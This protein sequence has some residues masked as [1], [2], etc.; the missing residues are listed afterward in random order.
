M[1]E[2][3]NEGGTWISR[4]PGVC[5]RS[6]RDTPKAMLS[7]PSMEVTQRRSTLIGNALKAEDYRLRHAVEGRLNQEG[8]KAPRLPT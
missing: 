1:N 5:V 3:W 2:H 4:I 6:F 7:H 8:G